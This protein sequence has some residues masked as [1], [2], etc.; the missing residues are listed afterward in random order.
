MSKCPTEGKRYKV[1]RS[2]NNAYFGEGVVDYVQTDSDY[3]C[4]VYMDPFT[5][6]DGTTGEASSL[7][8]GVYKWVEVSNGG[9]R[10][11]RKTR[12]VRKTRRARKSRRN[13]H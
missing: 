1:Y 12:R 2:N 9:R 13:H 4:E 5:F 10:R 8:G 7:L 11:N 3:G 6:A